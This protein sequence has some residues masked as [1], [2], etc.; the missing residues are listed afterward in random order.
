MEITNNQNEAVNDIIEMVVDVI[1][2]GSREI[3]TTEAISR[4]RYRRKDDE[5]YRKTTF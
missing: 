2:N 5:L 4:K 1:G 3:D